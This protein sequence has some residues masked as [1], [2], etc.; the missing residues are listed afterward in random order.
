VRTGRSVVP[1][2]ELYSAFTVCWREL[3]PAQQLGPQLNLVHCHAK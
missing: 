3:Q 1:V 2:D